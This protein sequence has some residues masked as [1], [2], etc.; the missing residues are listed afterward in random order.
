MTLTE[1]GAWMRTGFFFYKKEF[2][3]THTND[4]A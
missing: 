3:V 1:A 4:S 2:I